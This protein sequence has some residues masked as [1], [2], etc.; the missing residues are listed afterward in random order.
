[1]PDVSTN[2]SK[3]VCQKYYLFCCFSVV[4]LL[5]LYIYDKGQINQ[6]CLEKNVQVHH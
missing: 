5:G 4:G 1:M 2:V 3:C 6:F